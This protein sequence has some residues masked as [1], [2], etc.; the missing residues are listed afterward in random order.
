VGFRAEET[1]TLPAGLLPG[2][3]GASLAGTTLARGFFALAATTGWAGGAALLGARLAGG[4]PLLAALFA[5]FSAPGRAGAARPPAAGV[6]LET[7]MR[8]TG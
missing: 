4:M 8:L 6:F 7:G 5:S 3:V 1:G 2:G